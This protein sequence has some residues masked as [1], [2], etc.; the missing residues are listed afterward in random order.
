MAI[1][2]GKITPSLQ[3]GGMASPKG[4]HILEQGGLILAGEALKLLRFR[5]IHCQEETALGRKNTP[6]SVA[7]IAPRKNKIL[8]QA[9]DMIASGLERSRLFNGAASF[10]LNFDELCS[11][12]GGGS[13]SLSKIVGVSS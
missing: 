3:V 12:F 11:C 5:S 2:A 4:D 13:L 7:S 6:Q 1:Q 8:L 9:H 10:F